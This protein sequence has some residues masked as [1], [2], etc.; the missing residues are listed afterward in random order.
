[1]YPSSCLFTSPLCVNIQQ[2]DPITEIG[3]PYKKKIPSKG[4]IVIYILV[5]AL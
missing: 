3:L 1:M 2:R 4:G 5:M